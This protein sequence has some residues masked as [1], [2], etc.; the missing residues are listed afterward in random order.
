MIRNAQAPTTAAR[1]L[2]VDDNK[3]GLVARK[4]VLEELGY[5][6]TTAAEGQEAL[7]QFSRSKFDLIITDYRMPRMN[8]LE[9]I[10]RVRES[11]ADLPII[12]ISGYADALG[13]DEANTGANVVIA[14]SANEVAQLVRSVNRLL[15][16]AAPRKPAVSQ[17][18]SSRLK[19]QTAN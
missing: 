2:L 12:L 13:F 16:R 6:I 8:G 19:R 18:S 7:E 17:V 14:K 10:S 5:R 1:I 4:T 3:L 11:S 9:L 15:R